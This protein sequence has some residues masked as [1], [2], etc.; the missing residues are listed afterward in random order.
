M[1]IWTKITGFLSIVI[2]GLFGALQV[3][4]R[5]EA[6]KDMDL[7]ESSLKTRKKATE[8]LVRGLNEESKPVNRGHFDK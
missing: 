5:K 8:A 1:N 2:A 6:E 3:Q 7:A 4:K